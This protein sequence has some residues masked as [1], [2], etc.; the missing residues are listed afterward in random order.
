MAGRGY[1]Y[2][3][4]FARQFVA[5]G[6]KEGIKEGIEEGEK[7]LLIKQLARKFGELSAE[8]RERIEAA[9]SE[10]VD[11]WGERV[12]TAQTLEQVFAEV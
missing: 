3:S 11:L 9:S 10:Q 5:E 1:E 6:R 12:L 4:E 8:V 7:K 2:V